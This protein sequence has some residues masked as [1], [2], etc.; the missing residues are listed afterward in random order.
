METQAINSGG[1]S[2]RRKKRKPITA[3]GSRSEQRSFRAQ[4][5]RGAARRKLVRRSEL[6]KFRLEGGSHMWA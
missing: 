2:G 5:F 1:L 6:R 4:C 3:G